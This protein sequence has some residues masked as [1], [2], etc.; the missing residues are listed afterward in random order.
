MASA[1]T[2]SGRGLGLHRG[3][4]LL[5]LL[6]LL[7]VVGGDDAIRFFGL[8]RH[9]LG[10]IGVLDH[11]LLLGQRG[12]GDGSVGIRAR[13]QVGGLDPRR[14]HLKADLDRRR[15]KRVVGI[16]GLQM[17]DRERRAADME[18][19]RG[20]ACENPEP[21]RRLLFGVEVRHL[22]VPFKA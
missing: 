10:K 5:F 15:A 1:A 11:R 19:E 14:H 4:L 21:P 3:D 18:R 6:R 8:G 16:V 9:L 2:D 13:R 12:R 17:R 7:G 20:N 22:S